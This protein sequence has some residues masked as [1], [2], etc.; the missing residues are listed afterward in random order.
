[1]GTLVLAL[2]VGAN[3]A[4]VRADEVIERV[5]AVVAGDLILLSDA[6]AARDFG[7]VVPGTGADPIRSVLSQLIDRSLILAEVDRYAPPEPGAEAVDLELRGVR[8]RFPSPQTLDAALAGAGIDENHLRE[9][10]R[11]NLRIRAYLDQRFATGG[12][13]QQRAMIDE[14]VAGLRRRSEILDLYV[15][16]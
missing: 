16:R 10:V 2:V 8:G 3:G 13:D 15:S 7:L 5:L 4:V 11:E 14:W 12:P 6:K 1:M 9:T